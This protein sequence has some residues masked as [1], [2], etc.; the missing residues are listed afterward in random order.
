MKNY[1]GIF[2]ILCAYAVLYP[3]ITE[4][5]L[6]VAGTVEKEKLIAVGK[7]FIQESP[8]TPALV[9]NLVDMVVDNLDVSGSIDAFNKTRSILGTAEELYLN[10]HVFV[11]ILIIVFSV[12]VPLV[13][14][15][16]LLSLLLPLRKAIKSVLLTISDVLSKW[17]MADV[18][19]IAIFIAFLASNGIRENSG[20][21][22]FDASLG[23]GFWFFLA[24]CLISILGTQL[25]S[26]GM[27]KR[28]KSSNTETVDKT[29]DLDHSG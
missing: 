29:P 13:K 16:L 14:A 7:Q 26:A 23:R 3:G 19:V 6:T 11:A 8:D 9:N 4:P 18:F 10:H 17:S 24:Y 25:I 28:L 27:R 15:L 5:I 1:L 21:V 22:N 12:V 2:L 20:L